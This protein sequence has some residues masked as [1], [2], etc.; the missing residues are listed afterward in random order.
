[1][2]IYAVINIDSKKV[3]N[4]FPFDDIDN[5]PPPEGIIFIDVTGMDVQI[6]WDYIDGQFV[7]PPPPYVDPR[8]AI[9]AELDQI[10]RN[11]AR[12]LRVLII[13]DP[14][15][16]MGTPERAELEALELRAAELRAELEALPPPPTDT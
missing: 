4:I 3:V 16:G 6:G 10:D 15:V 11:S 14:D 12:P 5:F 7:E 13:A 8:P 1:M 9:Y 2:N